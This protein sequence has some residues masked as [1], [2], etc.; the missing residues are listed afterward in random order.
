MN[1]NRKG[2]IYA[3]INKINGKVYIGQ[4]KQTLQKRWGR[5]SEY[6]TCTHF[7][8]AIQ[9]YGWDNFQ[10]IVLECGLN[11]DEINEKEEYWINYYNSI[12]NGYNIK[13]GGGNIPFT[14]E[15]KNN[16][17]IG[18]TKTCGHKVICLNT[19][20]IYDSINS[21]KKD[22]GAEHIEKCCLGKLQ[23]AGRDAEGNALI[24]RYIEDYNPEEKIEIKKQI[25]K[26]TPIL[27]VT[28]GEIYSSIKEAS[29]QTNIDNGSICK[30]CN[31][32]RKSA[33]KTPNGEPMV[34][35]F[36]DDREDY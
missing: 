23:S 3:H 21:A 1:K 31:G 30:C 14:E 5:G 2:A 25:R 6:S 15:H 34:W 22:T 20:K 18:L 26:K 8:K 13:K 19:K 29:R 27:C 7:Y 17:S 36:L 10:H 12:E 35:Q 9:K 11:D 28:T 33:G 32:K 4:T 16:I 24:W